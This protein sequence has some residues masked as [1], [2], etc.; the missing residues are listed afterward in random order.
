MNK[1]QQKKLAKQL[2]M[3]EKFKPIV[4]RA[5]LQTLGELFIQGLRKNGA[6]ISKE[7]ENRIIEESL[8]ATLSPDPSR[9][10]SG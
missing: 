9:T 4:F 3:D 7:E 1:R 10:S 5:I 8:S 6:Q 2:A